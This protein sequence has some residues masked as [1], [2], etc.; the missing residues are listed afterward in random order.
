MQT[1]KQDRSKLK[2]SCEEAKQTRTQQI[3]TQD[4][5]LQ[6]AATTH[7]SKLND[8]LTGEREC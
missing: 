4:K 2:A 7:N 8:R 5:S 3:T 6:A 1:Q